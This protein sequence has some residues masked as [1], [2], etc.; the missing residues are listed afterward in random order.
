MVKSLW[1]WVSKPAGSPISKLAGQ[2]HKE[3]GK[4]GIVRRLGNPRYSRLGSLRY[5]GH[6]FLADGVEFGFGSVM[7]SE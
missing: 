2:T 5:A 1:H 6:D 7:L 3:R 4:P